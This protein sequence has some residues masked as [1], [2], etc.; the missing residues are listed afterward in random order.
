MAYLE[1]EKGRGRRFELHAVRDAPAL[2]FYARFGK[3]AFDLICVIALL[4]LWSSLSAILWAFARLETGTGCFADE[5]IGQFGRR[6][7]CLKIRTMRPEAIRRCAAY[8]SAQDP[9]I[10]RLGYIL[11]R[12]SL[13]EVPQLWCV[14]KGEMSL[15][16]PRPVPAAELNLYGAQRRSYLQMRPGLTGLWQVSGRNALSYE[17][18]I[19]L[20]VQYARSVSFWNDLKILLATSREVVLLSG[21]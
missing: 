6:F 13:D 19:A 17:R 11:R 7:K 3:R 2:G 12:S 15:V 21:R 16:G 14:L 4:P 1:I 8:K 9:R 10:T 20:D 5:R 18:R